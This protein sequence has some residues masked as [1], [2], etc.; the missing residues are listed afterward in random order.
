MTTTIIDAAEAMDNL[1]RMVAAVKGHGMQESKFSK[2]L[3]ALETLS[4][5]EGIPLVLPVVE[6]LRE[7]SKKIGVPFA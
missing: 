2:V 3:V 1:E 4:R 7:I 6:D 5:K